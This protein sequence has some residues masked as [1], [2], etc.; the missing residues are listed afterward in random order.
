LEDAGEFQKAERERQASNVLRRVADSAAN[1]NQRDGRK[2]HKLTAGI[3]TGCVT[4][5][6]VSDLMRHHSGN[7]SF[8]IGRKDQTRIVEEKTTGKGKSM[9]VRGIAN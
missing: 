2:V 8:V 6:Y 7:L 9:D 3:L 1:K 4:S 5:G